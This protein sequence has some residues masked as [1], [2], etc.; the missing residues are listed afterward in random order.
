MI[1]PTDS[2]SKS[3]SWIVIPPRLGDPVFKCP[4]CGHKTLSPSVSCENCGKMMRM[5]YRM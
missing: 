1:K 4:K 5:E 3:N 2:Y